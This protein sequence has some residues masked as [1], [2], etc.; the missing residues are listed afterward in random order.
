MQ[1]VALASLGGLPQVTIP[2]GTENG[3]EDGIPLAFSVMGGHGCDGLLLETA[4]DL[5]RGVR[6]VAAMYWKRGKEGGGRG[7]EQRAEEAKNR[8]GAAFVVLCCV[9]VTLS[10]LLTKPCLLRRFFAC[11]LHEEFIVDGETSNSWVAFFSLHL[12]TGIFVMHF[13]SW[14]ALFLCSVFS[15]LPFTSQS[16]VSL[17]RLFPL[18]VSPSFLLGLSLE[19]EISSLCCSQDID[20]AGARPVLEVTETSKSSM[21]ISFFDFLKHLLGKVLSLRVDPVQGNEAVKA[22]RFTEAVKHYNEAIRLDK[23]NPVYF[24]NKALALMQIGR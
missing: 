23:S 19:V 11:A 8:V 10:L 15:R 21:T 5:S 24:S 4:V 18:A 3:K 12:T 7:M 2:V 13:C 20:Y 1:L 6:K 14:A 16:F 17:L 22:K 9:Y